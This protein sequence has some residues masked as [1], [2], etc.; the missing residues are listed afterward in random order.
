M[1][2]IESWDLQEEILKLPMEK[3]AQYG[4][5]EHFHLM[6]RVAKEGDEIIVSVVL[7]DGMQ[8]RVIEVGTQPPIFLSLIVQDGNPGTITTL[9]VPYGSVRFL[10][11][12]VKLT[13]GREKIRVSFPRVFG[14]PDS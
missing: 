6:E 2:N 11:E 14:S 12:I 10:F 8:Y 13:P 1:A 4:I 7:P 5:K 9:L 3:Q